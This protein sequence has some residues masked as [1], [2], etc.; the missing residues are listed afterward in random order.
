MARKQEKID[1]SKMKKV[2]KISSYKDDTFHF[3]L[4]FKGRLI[5]KGR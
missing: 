4:S 2:K 5:Y 1:F 3:Y